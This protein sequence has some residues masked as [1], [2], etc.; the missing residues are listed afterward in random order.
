MERY[1]IVPS[2]L[3]PLG[4]FGS[5]EKALNAIC[6]QCLND[7]VKE[8]AIFLDCEDEIIEDFNVDDNVIFGVIFPNVHVWE[9]FQSVIRGE[10]VAPE[11]KKSFS[12][13]WNILFLIII[14]STIFCVQR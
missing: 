11:I 5:M 7:C 9:S 6:I 12:I 1:F 3:T 13:C 14:L 10:R 4:H 2:Y 8:G